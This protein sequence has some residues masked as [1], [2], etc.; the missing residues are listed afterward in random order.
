MFAT[1][2][3]T[4]LREYR[5][6]E[7]SA[8]IAL[9][10]SEKHQY[11]T[12]AGISRVHLGHARAESG[13]VIEGIL[14]MRRGIDDLLRI[15]RHPGLSRWILFLATAQQRTGQLVDALETV[16]QAL[17][18]NPEVLIARPEGLRVCGE[19]RFKEGEIDRA[20]ADFRESI[21]LARTMGAKALELRSTMSLARL[22]DQRGRRDEARAM[23]A[24][25]YDWFIEGFDIADLKE[26][27]TLLEQF[28]AQSVKCRS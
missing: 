25:I 7:A 23:L 13:R 4:L 3:Q 1:I 12:F 18:L 2:V 11:S 14:L 26:A 6:A 5:Q 16:E 10:L 27:K 9:E 28:V 17:R 20:E 21:A 8:A 19:I 15:G 22:L 24:E